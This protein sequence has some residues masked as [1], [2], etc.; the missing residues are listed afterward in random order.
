MSGPRYLGLDPG[1]KNIGVVFHT[2]G[3]WKATTCTAPDLALGHLV[4]YHHT[5][6]KTL[7]E[8][9]CPTVVLVES[10]PAVGSAIITQKLS[11]FLASTYQLA[12]ARGILHGVVYPSVWQKVYK[13]LFG[14]DKARPKKLQYV[15]F[16][17][18][19]LHKNCSEH[20]A[21]ALGCVLA[22]CFEGRLIDEGKIRWTDYNK[23]RLPVFNQPVLGP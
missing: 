23:S 12:Q 22:A 3:S 11:F 9:T 5:L 1:I 4:L 15:E 10:L 18:K 13:K 19:I 8:E 2:S 17:S 20:E 14:W 6:L 21:S 16:A 7:F